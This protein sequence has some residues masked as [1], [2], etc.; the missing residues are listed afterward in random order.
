ML[1]DLVKVSVFNAFVLLR[2]IEILGFKD[3]ENFPLRTNF[4]SI[5]AVDSSYGIDFFYV[6]FSSFPK[7]LEMQWKGLCGLP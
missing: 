7:G 6:L 3:L 5:Y 4:A 1:L 2:W